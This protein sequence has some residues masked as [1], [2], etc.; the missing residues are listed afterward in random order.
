MI[1]SKTYSSSN[2]IMKEVTGFLTRSR[3]FYKISVHM[4]FKHLELLYLKN[5]IREVGKEV[6]LYIEDFMCG[7]V[8]RQRPLLSLMKKLGFTWEKYPRTLGEYTLFGYYL[9]KMFDNPVMGESFIEMCYDKFIPT[10]RFEYS[11]ALSTALKEGNF[12]ESLE[13][14]LKNPIFSPVFSGKLLGV[15]EQELNDLKE[16]PERYLEWLNS[17]SMDSVKLLKKEPFLRKIFES[18]YNTVLDGMDSIIFTIRKMYSGKSFSCKGFIP[19]YMVD[20]KNRKLIT[21]ATGELELD[22]RELL[23]HYKINLDVDP[24]CPTNLSFKNMDKNEYVEHILF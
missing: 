10:A 22:N 19:Y 14:R 4:S 12:K 20:F 13:E 21:D 17:T 3:F 2:S 7:T 11:S 15:S 5:D 8:Q 1:I 6:P 16:N 18:I 23:T 24:L 9:R